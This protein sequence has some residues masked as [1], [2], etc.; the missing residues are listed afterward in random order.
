MFGGQ[1]VPLKPSGRAERAIDTLDHYHK[2]REPTG[3]SRATK[4]K[5]ITVELVLELFFLMTIAIYSPDLETGPRGRRSGPGS[6]I[7]DSWQKNS[8]TVVPRCCRP[9]PRL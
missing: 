8:A 9:V 6:Q 1:S 5:G 3:R 4:S 2:S 7:V